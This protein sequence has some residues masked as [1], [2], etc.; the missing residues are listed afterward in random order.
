MLGRIACFFGL[1]RFRPWAINSVVEPLP[2]ERC[3]RC[4]VGRKWLTCGVELRY[5]R[6]QMAE[7]EED[8]IQREA[9]KTSTAGEC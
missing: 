3:E 4:G 1:H 7:A 9:A 6:E 8:L 2:V 5:S